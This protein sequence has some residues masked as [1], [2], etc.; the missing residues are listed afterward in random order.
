MDCSMAGRRCQ[1][2][3][4]DRCG[5]P[6]LDIPAAATHNSTYPL[7]NLF[8]L[9]FLLRFRDAAAPR[10]ARRPGGIHESRNY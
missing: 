10:R 1:Q 4:F 9:R 8:C 3:H 6:Q 7:S 2:G 5:M